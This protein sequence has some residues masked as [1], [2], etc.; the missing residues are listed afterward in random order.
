[1]SWNML[2]IG[3]ISR[4]KK[5]TCSGK[6]EHTGTKPSL[7]Y[8]FCYP[9]PWIFELIYPVFWHICIR[10]LTLLC[11][12][13]Q[14]PMEALMSLGIFMSSFYPMLN[15]EWIHTTVHGWCGQGKD[16]SSVSVFC[17]PSIFM[18]CVGVSY[19]EMPVHLPDV[20][21]F[22]QWIKKLLNKR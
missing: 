20:A 21:E 8:R 10:R 22:S 6:Y 9:I 7:M 19:F 13:M 15:T 3:S 12:K 14:Y 1:M 11:R 2:K 16:S 18:N 17:L 5:S 4:R